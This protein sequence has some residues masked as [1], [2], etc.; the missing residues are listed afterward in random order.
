MV[1]IANRPGGYDETLVRDMEPLLLTCANIIEALRIDDERV[2]AEQALR[3]SEDC[4]RDLVENSH[5]L[6]CTHDLE[7]RILSIN[8][9]AAR[10]LGYDQSALVNR[11]L[12]EIIVPEFRNK[13]DAYL[14]T[15]KK[16]GFADGLMRIQNAAGEVR[17]WEYH[18]T[19]RTEGVTAPI[20]RG[21]AHDLT[22]RKRAEEEINRLAQAIRSISEC[23]CICDL[24][25][26][27]TFVNDAFVNTYGY[28]RDELIGQ[29]ID[30][31]RL[32]SEPA[33]ALQQI[34][35]E[36]ISGG[37]HGELINRKKDGT[38]FPIF[39]STSVVEDENQRPIALVG[40]AL[41][42]TER[43]QAEQA[44]LQTQKLESL[45]VLAGGIAHDFNNLL[46]GILGNA[47]LALMELPPESPAHETVKQI[48]TAG[49]RAAELARQ[50][51]A[52]SG[53]GHFVIQPL[54]LNLLIEEMAHLLQVAISKSVVLK[55]NFARDLAVIEADATQI[56]QIVM[57]LVVNAAEAIGEENGIITITTGAMH[58]DCEYLA[59][60]YP[61]PDPKPGDYVFLEVTDSGCGMDAE[62]QTK[63]FDPFFTTKF[64]GRGLGLAAVLGIVRGHKGAIKIS[65]TPGQGT[66]FTVLLPSIE[67][68]AAPMEAEHGLRTSSL[69]GNRNQ[70]LV[71]DD[72]DTVRKVTA[73]VL[74]KLGFSVL[75]AAGGRDGIEAFR[76]HAHEI[77]CVLLDLTMPHPT[78][79]EV[80]REIRRL[81]PDTPVILMSGYSE[82]EAI[83]HFA[84]P[85]PAPPP[86]GSYGTG[87]SLLH[88]DAKDTERSAGI[89]G[90]LKKPYTPDE[91]REQL[92]KAY[93]WSKS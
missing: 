37:W 7:G 50:M 33:S 84:G 83:S 69:S 72:D 67:T 41:D 59:E 46:V 60:A 82:Q 51:L 71:I 68:A 64:T 48:E 65:S 52:Y 54:N 18:N 38:E 9:G 25:D 21:L 24:N 11:N 81:K 15:I 90:F 61:M 12:R 87:R 58:V 77:T 79:E 34:H 93:H 16:T 43:K 6:I 30:L 53:K 3:D 85:V 14:E 47:G 89:A 73:R 40:V 5:D 20:V 39:L 2:Q 63:I 17:L 62:T 57:N 45:G 76:N 74:E 10:T 42:I 32:P 86:K 66:T 23:I 75:Q 35:Q 26:R 49:Q 13:V 8:R 28:G 56:R 92:E 78:G 31:V 27:I 22:E 1:G 4:Y 19:L 70:V 88:P 80:F 44:L 36:T 29:P 91:L 55:F